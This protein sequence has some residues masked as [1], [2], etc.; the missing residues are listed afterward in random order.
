MVRSDGKLRV[1]RWL[2]LFARTEFGIT[3]GDAPIGAVRTR[4]EGAELQFGGDAVF[5]QA[6]TLGPHIDDAGLPGIKGMDAGGHE[7]AIDANTV[8]AIIAFH[9]RGKATGGTGEARHPGAGRL[10]I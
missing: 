10:G 9:G 1:L 8:L 3:T 6:D 5:S 4:L 2:D 7:A